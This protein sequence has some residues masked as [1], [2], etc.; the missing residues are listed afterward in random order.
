MIT[1]SVSRR[2]TA[3]RG[4]QPGAASR[5]LPYD[6]AQKGDGRG[7]RP[8]AG[9][10]SL[11]GRD[12]TTD[13]SASDADSPRDAEAV[14]QFPS[15]LPMLL[16]RAREAVLEPTRP[17]LRRHALTE[18]QWR[19]L[20]TLG[21]DGE[22]ETLRLATAVFLRPPSVTR[23]VR[24]LAAKGHVTRRPDPQD[25]RV[26]LVAI[27]PKGQAIVDEVLP[28]IRDLARRMRIA[29]GP[30]A[31]AALQRELAELIETVTRMPA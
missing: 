1:F 8:A 31:I 22:M 18:P 29:Y 12:M 19:V 2:G 24:D 5:E 15:T 30:E 14:R 28:L 9:P 6:R 10:T 25:G 17:I 21:A 20:R 7:R 16:L 23:I 4:L 13:S 11:R 3:S 26:M 27:S